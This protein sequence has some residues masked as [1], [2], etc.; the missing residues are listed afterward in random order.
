MREEEQKN[1]CEGTDEWRRMARK[2]KKLEK[3]AREEITAEEKENE[4]G[5]M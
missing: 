4:R 1:K 3:S 5:E 2:G